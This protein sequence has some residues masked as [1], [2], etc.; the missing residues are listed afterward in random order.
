MRK[1]IIAANANE[2]TLQNVKKTGW[3]GVFV[4]WDNSFQAEEVAMRIRRM[5]LMLQSIHAPFNGI[6]KIWE[7]ESGE[8]AEAELKDQITCLRDTAK[9]DCDLVVM[10]AIIGMERHTPTQIGVERFA[11]LVEEAKRLGVRIAVENTEGEI[12]LKTLLDAFDCEPHVGFCIDT[13]HE[14]CYNG[15]TDMIGK[16]GKRLFGTHLNDNLG[17]TGDQITWLDDAHILPFDGVGD[18]A[19]IAERL[20][21]VGFDGPLTFELNQFNRPG[22]HANDRYAAMTDAEFLAVA[23][24]HARCF[25]SLMK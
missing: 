20:K 11:K 14:L 21:K 1:L 24:E 19:G 9:A 15:A 4:G 5:G 17:M 25:A 7:D 16:Y 10:H 8:L 3:D 22:R 6:W 23:Y 12:Y 13:G 2:D 18:W